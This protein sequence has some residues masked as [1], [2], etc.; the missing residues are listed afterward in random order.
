MRWR[1][2]RRDSR[3]VAIKLGGRAK[4]SSTH[5]CMA[6]Q[7]AALLRP[8]SCLTAVAPTQHGF[9][10][11]G[12][13]QGQPLPCGCY[14]R[15]SRCTTISAV[16]NLTRRAN[17]RYVFIVARIRPAPENP[18]RAFCIHRSEPMG[19]Q[20]R[21]APQADVRPA[22]TMGKPNRASTLPPLCASHPSSTCR[23]TLKAN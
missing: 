3:F 12:A 17:H 8:L 1:N 4:A 15:R 23:Q 20:P 2:G 22:K 18:P 9:C 5:F 7:Y 16:N 19:R 14:F 21:P 10:R 11:G 6:A 13:R